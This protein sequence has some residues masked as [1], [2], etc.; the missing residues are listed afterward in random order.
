MLSQW[1]DIMTGSLVQEQ[2]CCR[3]GILA[4]LLR[5]HIEGLSFELA[6]GYWVSQGYNSLALQHAASQIPHDTVKKIGYGHYHFKN[7]IN[8]YGYIRTKY[9][10]RFPEFSAQTTILENKR[11]Y[12]YF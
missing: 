7:R 9:V 10:L 4:P 11:L 2:R 8:K 5:E 6:A 1:K 3:S 12:S